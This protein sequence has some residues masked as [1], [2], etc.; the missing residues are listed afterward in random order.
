MDIVTLTGRVRS[1]FARQILAVYC[2]IVRLVVAEV[3][4]PTGCF[5]VAVFCA[6]CPEDVLRLAFPDLLGGLRPG[7]IYFAVFVCSCCIIIVLF[8]L[9]EFYF[10]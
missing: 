1:P 2:I 9:I 5:D 6:I 4:P 3:V 10:Y 8:L 7:R